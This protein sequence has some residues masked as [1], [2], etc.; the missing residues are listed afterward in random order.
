MYYHY[1]TQLNG[2]PDFPESAYIVMLCAQFEI[3]LV[4]FAIV[5]D[6]SMKE[7]CLRPKAEK[8][9]AIG[10]VHLQR[11]YLVEQPAFAVSASRFDA[12]SR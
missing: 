8:A 12:I 1:N 5:G 4:L 2:V 3:M 10:L 7:E 6:R 9:R 11:Q